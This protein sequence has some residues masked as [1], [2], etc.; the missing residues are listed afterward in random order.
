MPCVC[1]NQRALLLSSSSNMCH[2]GMPELHKVP[3][4]AALMLSS[5]HSLESLQ[6]LEGLVGVN[7]I[8]KYLQGFSGHSTGAKSTQQSAVSS[9]LGPD[10]MSNLKLVDS[11]Y[12]LWQRFPATASQEAMHFYQSKCTPHLSES[13]DSIDS[14]T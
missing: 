3:R 11:R 12:Q 6:V 1:T 4:A 10:P 14:Q 13:H 5:N 9:I 8:L 7:A 2:C